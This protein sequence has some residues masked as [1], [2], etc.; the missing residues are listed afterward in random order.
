MDVIKE[1]PPIKLITCC[2]ATFKTLSGKYFTDLQFLLTSIKIL[3]K[4]DIVGEMT[5]VRETTMDTKLNRKL[6][7]LLIQT[8]IY[9]K[10]YNV[11]V[12]MKY[13]I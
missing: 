8:L 6:F 4:I 3:L 5:N 11:F 7:H 9:V 2:K 13:F 10:Q 1:Q 12:I